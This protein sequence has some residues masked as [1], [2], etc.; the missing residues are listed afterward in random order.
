MVRNAF[1]Y[2]FLPGQGPSLRE[3]NIILLKR[4]F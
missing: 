2:G 4:R 3:H 1:L